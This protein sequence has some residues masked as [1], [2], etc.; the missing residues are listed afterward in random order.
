[1]KDHGATI[2][3]VDDDA[4]WR[5][6]LRLALEG[7]AFHVIEVPH[8]DLALVA[9]EQHAPDVVVLDHHMPGLDGLS[10]IGLLRRRW[11]TLPLVLT[12][13]FCDPVTVERALRAGATR[14]LD[15][16]FR[17]RALLAEI[18]A[19]IKHRQVS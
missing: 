17:L 5:N 13:A 6:V 18:E 1:M 3:I 10:L 16:P 11:P 8:G 19:L 12:S 2:L 9:V 4:E 7:A 14:Y 15:K